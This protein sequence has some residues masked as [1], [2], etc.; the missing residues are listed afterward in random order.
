MMGAPIAP[1]LLA[2]SAGVAAVG[3]V[4]FHTPHS[5]DTL[6]GVRRAWCRLRSATRCAGRS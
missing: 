1:G 3:G 6:K 4:E 5:G 2:A